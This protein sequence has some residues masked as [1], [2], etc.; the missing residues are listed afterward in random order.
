MRLKKRPQ[1]QGLKTTNEEDLPSPIPILLL[2][3]KPKGFT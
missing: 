1:V 2:L 3:H